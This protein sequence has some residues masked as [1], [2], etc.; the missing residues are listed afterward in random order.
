MFVNP[1]G[2]LVCFSLMQLKK[3]LLSL[4]EETFLQDS[5]ANSV[6]SQI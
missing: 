5:V 3:K 4:F 1:K 6:H 2:L